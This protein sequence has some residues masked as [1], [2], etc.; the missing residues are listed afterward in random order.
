MAEVLWR[1]PDPTSTPM[2]RFLQ[3]VKEKYGLKED[4]YESLYAWSVENVGEFWEECWDFVG[5]EASVG[6]EKV[7]EPSERG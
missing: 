6:Y 3:K 5:I 7:S 4:T 2:W 1:H